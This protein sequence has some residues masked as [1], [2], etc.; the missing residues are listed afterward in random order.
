MGKVISVTS[1]EDMGKAAAK[2]RQLSMTYN[3]IAK[4]LMQQASTM[5]S[6][7]E[8]ADNADFVAQI[9]GFTQ[10]LEIMAQRLDD[11]GHTLDEQKQ[12]YMDRQEFNSTAVK[13]LVN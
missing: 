13:K 4:Q 3:D 10:E 9:T 6:A 11:A 8:G 5:G 12:N 1:F 7:W 2:L